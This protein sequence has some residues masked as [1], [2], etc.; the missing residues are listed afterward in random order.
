MST[1]KCVRDK[2]FKLF[3]RMYGTKSL[4]IT[5]P[6]YCRGPGIS[7]SGLSEHFSERTIPGIKSIQ[8]I[9]TSK[10]ETDEGESLMMPNRFLCRLF[11]VPVGY[12]YV[13]FYI[14]L[15]CFNVK[16]YIYVKIRC[17]HFFS[18]MGDPST[19]S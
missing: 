12:A 18:E 8:S 16:T 13:S 4:K 2:T 7:E 1:S 5:D 3:F 11:F 6:I 15:P 9:V 17:P 10:A 14:H 19:I